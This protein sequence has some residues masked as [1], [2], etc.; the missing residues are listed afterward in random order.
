MG[1]KISIVMACKNSGHTISK[2]IKSFL[3][4]NY[5]K[6]ELIIVDGGSTDNTLNEINRFKKIDLIIKKENCGLYDSINLGIKKSSGNIIALLHSDDF[7]YNDQIL[8]KINQIFYNN[9]KLEVIYSNIVFVDKY[10]KIKRK[11]ISGIINSNNI[12]CG[13]FPPHTGIFVK[14]DLFK[15]IGYYKSNYKIASDIGWM[16]KIF[17]EKKIETHYLNRYTV[18]M[19]IGGLSTKSFKNICISNYEAYKILKEQKVKNIKL[20]ILKKILSKLSQLN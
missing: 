16:H 5:K 10:L 13:I 4:Q 15:K 9:K 12:N 2:S 18:K 17:S 20:L 19:S 8:D 6:K 11:W 1:N 3:S 7:F 14:K